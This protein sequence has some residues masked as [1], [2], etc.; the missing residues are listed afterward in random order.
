MQIDEIINRITAK[1]NVKTTVYTHVNGDR[2][3]Q[4]AHQKQQK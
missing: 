3:S 1:I 4:F 2:R